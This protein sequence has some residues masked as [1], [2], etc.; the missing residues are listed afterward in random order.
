MTTTPTDAYP[1]GLTIAYPEEPRNRLTTFFRP[2]V[3]IPIMLV[4][5]LLSSYGNGFV[6]LTTLLMILFRRKYPRWW[7]DWNVQLLRFQTRGFAYLLLLGDDYP[8]TDDEQRVVLRI[9]YPNAEADLNRWLPLIKW[10]LALPHYIVLSFLWF[11]VAVVT[12]IAWFAILFTGRYPRGLFD[13]AVGVNRWTVRVFAYAFLLTTD[14]YP[15]F[16]MD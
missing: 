9:E 13:F 12:V 2:I 11:A 1:V 10:L 8:A 4:Q 5:W 7:F 15:P 16:S 6:V 14:R 3:A